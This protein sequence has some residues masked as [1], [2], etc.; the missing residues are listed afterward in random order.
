M[1][2]ILD[3]QMV[4]P[5]KN[6]TI[7]TERVMPK[8]IS[9]KRTALISHIRCSSVQQERAPDLKKVNKLFQTTVS[10]QKKILQRREGAP[11]VL[12][13]NN[14]PVYANNTYKTKQIIQ[15]EL[16]NSLPDEVPIKIAKIDTFRNEEVLAAPADKAEPTKPTARS[17][18]AE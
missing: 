2:Y 13:V 10:V 16:F 3:D 8:P 18:K 17:I 1:D 14:S 12:D 7:T 9:S 15:A 6:G 11:T 5:H 4:V